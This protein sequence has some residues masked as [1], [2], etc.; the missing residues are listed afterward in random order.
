MSQPTITDLLQTA[1]PRD[2]VAGTAAE[3]RSFHAGA[4]EERL[5][6]YARM[7]NHY[8][9]LVTD[10]YEYGWGQSFHF[11]P[12][13]RGESFPASIA[14]HEFF[15]S[16]QLGLRPGMTVIDLG[17][18]V[19]G[20]MRAIA[21]FSGAQVVGINNNQYQIKKGEAHTRAAGLT[22]RCRFV[23]ADFMHL[24]FA[25]ASIDAAYA[26]EATCHAPDKTALFREIAR[27]LKPGARFAG[28]E[29]CLTPKYDP[30]NAEHRAIKKGIE[31][32]DGL[33]DLWPEE[34]VVNALSRA[35][36]EVVDGRDL[37]RDP[38]GE[39]PWYQP[40]AGEWS[41][42]GFQRTRAGRWVTHRLVRVL[43]WAR[44]APRGTVE[45]SDFLNVAADALVRGGEMGI[46]T[47]MF[48]FHGK[49]P[50]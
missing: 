20:P 31:V 18:G 15:L 30:K 50:G 34:E 28:Y 9:D 32:G 17:C 16:A 5:S 43:E 29:W 33:P 48:F 36:F 19:G 45:V 42:N 27:V 12:R 7:V 10:F 37:A 35:G 21:R 25:D 2:E 13:H 24:P 11:A 22:D 41:I 3:Y 26:I 1:M 4:A 46:F 47:P 23:K 8:Y 39:T 44:V 38:A 40:L 6:G 49:K 14:R